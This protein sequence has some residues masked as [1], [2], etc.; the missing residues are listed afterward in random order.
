MM[1]IVMLIIGIVGVAFGIALNEYN[2]KVKEYSDMLQQKDKHLVYVNKEPLVLERSEWSKKEWE[3][4]LEVFGMVWADHIVLYEYKF[5][6]FG[7]AKEE[8]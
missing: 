5:E 1:Y 2:K 3:T 4:I 7:I 6:S 8:E